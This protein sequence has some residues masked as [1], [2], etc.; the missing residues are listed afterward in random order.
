MI[1]SD[2]FISITELNNLLKGK[3]ERDPE[4]A[5]LIV[6]GEISSWNRYPN[7]IY[8]DLKDDKSVVSCIMFVT[9]YSKLSYEPK[10]GEEVIVRGGISVYAPRGRYNLKTY[11]IEPFGIGKQLLA[12]E[13][14]KKKLAQEGL[15]DQERKREIPS[16]PKTIGLIVGEGSAAEADLK[17]NLQ[18]RWP[19]ADI[20]IF[21]SLVQGKD[22]PKD[23]LRAF[24]LS[25]QY[26]LDTL[27]IAR[28][29][30]S[31]EDLDAFNDETLVRAFATSKMPTI[32]AV[33]HE[34]D[35]TLIDYVSDRRV[36]TPTGAAEAA[37]PDKEEITERII[38]CWERILF[39]TKSK[40]NRFEESFLRIKKHPFFLNPASMYEEKRKDLETL[41]ARMR[42]RMGSIL[43]KDCLTISGLKGKL[44]ALNPKGVL[45]RGY[46]L[47]RNKEGKI[48]KSTK[49]LKVGDTIISELSDGTVISRVEEKQNG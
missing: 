22:A 29:G 5:N 34:I 6:K 32:S 4:L 11:E 23:L 12:L 37:T 21:P 2:K 25:Q 42:K 45:S 33:G 27:I 31:S 43:E 16:F 39:S 7:A 48:I 14:L 15:F 49:D 36:S 47:T 24:N 41:E 9:P 10:I 35:T 18:R 26:P 46:S 19:M 8:F 17:R 1:I 38:D 3:L 40:M 44:K 28:G 20:I 13:M 30:G